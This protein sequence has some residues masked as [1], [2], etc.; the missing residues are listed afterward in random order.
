MHRLHIKFKINIFL[1]WAAS[2][3]LLLNACSTLPDTVE[4]DP[5]N[6]PPE[7]AAIERLPVAS[8][9]DMGKAAEGNQINFI[10]TDSIRDTALSLGARNGLAYRAKQINALL[11][12]QAKDLDAVFNFER[13]LLEDN[14]LPPVLLESRDALTLAGP[15]TMRVSD[16]SYRIIKQARFVTLPPT[17]REYLIMD[18]RLPEKPDASLLPKTEEEYVVWVDEV[19]LGWAQG[20]KQANMIYEENLSRLKRDYQGMVRYRLLLTQKMVSAPQVAAR[21]LGVTGGGE[22]LSVNDRL[23]T[24]QALPSLKADSESWQPVVTP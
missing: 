1:L 19:R 6:T 4:N 16:R 20:L 24:I 17:W 5:A 11:N 13:L 22:E 21:D 23:F 18:D 15:Q 8:Q 12:S 2:L 10:R 3:L 9:P 7:L 14:I